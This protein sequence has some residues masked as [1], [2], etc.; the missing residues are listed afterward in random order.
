MARTLPS[1]ETMQTIATV[2]EQQRLWDVGRPLGFTAVTLMSHRIT[3]LQEGTDDLASS[4]ALILGKA[5]VSARPSRALCYILGG[6]H[7]ACL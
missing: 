1:T 2:R 6:A 4:K 3:T 7:W 5:D